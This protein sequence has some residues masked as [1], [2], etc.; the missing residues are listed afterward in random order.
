[1]FI[2]IIRIL[3]KRSSYR[4]FL[5]SF[6]VL[7]TL[8][9]IYNNN[10]F[11]FFLASKI[12]DLLLDSGLLLTKVDIND[13]KFTDK[14]DITKLVKKRDNIFSFS[15]RDLYN[16]II[17]Y[18]WVKH[19]SIT[20]I[21]P[22]RLHISITEYVPVAVIERKKKFFIIT[23]NGNLIQDDR[24]D[25]F[26]SLILISGNV[27]INKVLNLL[28]ILNTNSELANKVYF[29]EYIGNRR[30]NITFNNGILVKLPEKNTLQAWKYLSKLQ[31]KKNILH[32]KFR[33]IDIRIPNKI[34]LR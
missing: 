8:L 26:K 14:N 5:P 33:Y 12:N 11:N 18:K 10:T 9:F 16:T 31:N 6:V 23:K 3:C 13:L 34:F 25:L 1:M 29:A 28:S 2:K 32:D 15:V 22:N 27:K 19:C 7:L 24:I 30:W 20:R 21:I 17:N 4:I